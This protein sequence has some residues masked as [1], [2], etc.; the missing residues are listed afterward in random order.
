MGIVL[1][2][3]ANPHQTMQGTRRLVTVTGTELG[4]TQ[5]QVLVAFQALVENLHMARTVHR[6]DGV[7][8]LLGLRGKHVVLELVPVP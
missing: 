2:K 7:I 5:R 6:L 4:Q 3:S 8:V 1:G